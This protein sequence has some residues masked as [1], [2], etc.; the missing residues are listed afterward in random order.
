[1]GGTFQ[2]RLA[3]EAA[4]GQT[5]S[6]GSQLDRKRIMDYTPTSRR[7][8]EISHLF[9]SDVRSK[10]TEGT[11]RPA[12]TPPGGF[13]G[14]ASVDMTPEE[15]AMTLQPTVAAEPS[16]KPLRAVIAHHLGEAMATKVRDYAATLGGPVGVLYADDANVR[17]CRTDV[18]TDEIHDEPAVEALSL[19]RLREVIVELDQDVTQWL[20]VLPDVR[21]T[22][23]QALLRSVPTWTLLTTAEHDSVV[24]AYR[25]LKGVCGDARP[26]L[27]VAVCGAADADEYD[28]TVKK[29]SGVCGQFLSLTVKTGPAVGVAGGVSEVCL[30]EATADENADGHADSHWPVLA[31][32]VDG[33]AAVEE[34]AV[35]QKPVFASIPTPPAPQ[36]TAAAPREIPVESPKPVAPAAVPTAD[37]AMTVLELPA[38]DASPAAVLR[39]V[40]AGGGCVETSIKAP[41]SPDAVVAV[42]RD[43][44][45]TI[46]AAAA[47]GTTDWRAVASAL[48]WAS[49]NR[50]LIA[51]AVPQLSIDA[52]A[53]PTLKL[54]VDHSAAD[55]LPSQLAGDAM[56]VI[57]YRKVRFGGRLGVLLDAA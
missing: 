48:K 34:I 17:V 37:D 9:L 32:L 36:P 11:A 41:A 19:S 30:L 38:N 45:L 20:V 39:A 55:A 25:T 2:E 56:T 28:K 27:S 13:K 53:E 5:V 14:D 42:D 10:Q 16:F 49:D 1:M 44:R 12:R 24:A 33:A 29:L 35:T 46:L 43:R 4:N 50:Q 18:A 47:P 8:S 31:G 51:M 54:Y 7:L 15:F 52:F 21:S 6:C 57:A 22:E 3:S 23:A 40:V 26:A